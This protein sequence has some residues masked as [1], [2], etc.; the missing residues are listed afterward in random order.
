MTLHIITRSDTQSQ[1][2]HHC[3]SFIGENDILLFIEDGTYCILNNAL[4]KQ[5]HDKNIQ[6]YYLQADLVARGLTTT[7][8]TK[9]VDYRAFVTLTENHHPSQTWG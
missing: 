1:S 7:N 3:L 5:M 8:N 4:S 2:I 6:C 9:V